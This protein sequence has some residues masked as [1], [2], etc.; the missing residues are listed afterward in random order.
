MATS[1]VPT[2]QPTP[3]RAYIAS[4]PFNLNFFSYVPNGPDG[5]GFLAPVPG[6]NFTNCPAG[7]I[8]R[9]TGKKLYPD[10]NPGVP[11]LMVG[12]Y[13]DITLLRGYID[14]N[15]AAFAVYSTD[16]SNF[17]PTG[18]DPTTGITMPVPLFSRTA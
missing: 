4:I 11:T 17:Y 3:R 10:A 12:V 9:E 16:V 2:Y 6:A 1:V 7:R 13:D 18:V 5:V 15:A 14:P 8:L